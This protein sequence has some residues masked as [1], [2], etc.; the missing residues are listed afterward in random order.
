[1]PSGCLLLLVLASTA[2]AGGGVIGT[3]GFAAIAA[4]RLP[5]DALAEAGVLAAAG[6]VVAAGVMVAAGRAATGGVVTADPGVK[7]LMS[8]IFMFES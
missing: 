2:G 7:S 3:A 5:G 4:Q 1:M 8:P 6:V